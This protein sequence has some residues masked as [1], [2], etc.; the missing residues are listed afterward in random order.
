M[1][2]CRKSK[3]KIEQAEAFVLNNSGYYGIMFLLI[4][5]VTEVPIVWRMYIHWL[6]NFI[7][8]IWLPDRLFPRRQ[9]KLICG[10]TPGM[11][12]VMMS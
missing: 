9:W 2:P 10:A 3:E 6:K 1:A 4:Y 7:K 12:Q 5:K 8:R 11:V